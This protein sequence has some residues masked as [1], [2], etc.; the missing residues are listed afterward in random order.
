MDIE[1]LKLA[2]LVADRGGF[3]SAARQ[4]SL[5]PSAISRSIAGLEAELGVRLFQRST[6]RFSVTEAGARYLARVAPLIEEVERAGSELAD[7][8]VA[9]RGRLRLTASVAFGQQCVVPHIGAFRA[10]YPD[11]ALELFLSDAVLDPVD[12]GMDLAIRLAPSPT[13]DVISAKLIDT[14]YRVCASAAFAQQNGALSNP[15][16]LSD[17][18]C[19]RYTLPEFRSRWLFRDQEGTVQEV[20]VDGSIMISSA[21][22]MRQAARDGLGPALLADWLADDDLRTGRLVDL[23]P[24]YRVTATSFETAAYFLYPSRAF[25]PAK[26][27]VMIDFLRERIVRNHIE[28]STD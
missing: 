9:P 26:V 17:L 5:D 2:V 8:R 11:I 25:L 12:A 21:L 18:D 19:L 24:R 13:G 6:R 20:P 28:Q 23:F 27:R 14:R 16:D 3:A 10:R 15:G 4:L 22:A 7:A 1:T